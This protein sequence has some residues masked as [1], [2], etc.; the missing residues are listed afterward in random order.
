MISE[1]KNNNTN[2]N[3]NVNKEFVNLVVI[4]SILVM[5]V[6]GI[7]SF[8]A[9]RTTINMTDDAVS[10]V[11]SF[12]LEAM[13]DQRAQTISN[14][15]DYNF[16]HMEKAL[17]VL[18]SEDINTQEDLR[19][20]L[21]EIKT[22]LSL[23]RFALVDEDN[24]VYTQYTTYSGGSRYEFLSEE[25]L[26]KR[27]IST[28]SQYG[29]S[30]Q[31]CLAIPA[32]DLTIMGKKFKACFVQI[33][34]SEIADLLAFDE[35]EGSYFSLYV[36]NGGNLSDN[37]HGMLDKGENIL[38]ASREYLPQKSWEKL[39]DDFANGR[40]GN[41]TL[42]SE[43]RKE[44]I[45]YVPVH[46]TGW[47]LV[48]FIKESIINEQIHGISE[49]NRRTSRILIGV[50]LLS[51]VLFALVIILRLRKISKGRI[52]AEKENS[53][54]F[55]SMANTDSLTGIRNKH[56]Y[57]QYE[58]LMN[59]HIKDGT[60]KDNLAVLVCDINGL[61]HVN[62]TKGHAAGD[63]LIKDASVLI[64]EYFKHGAVFRIG[65]D[66]FVVV[67][68]EKGYDTLHETLDSIN[69]VIEENIAKESVVVSIGYSTLQEDD[70]E[71]HDVF[72]RADKMMYERK[73]QLKEMGSKTREN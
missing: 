55:F 4:G 1:D 30:K 68:N 33:D 18:E 58:S 35:N 38:E 46:D 5:L 37:D 65:G 64:C 25:N 70:K 44:E 14:L 41:L 7:S 31:L 2:T 26:D 54:M 15:I 60:V 57:S 21:G 24:I 51:M 20:R 59:Q 49:A 50:T 56:A 12:Y 40:G 36:Q 43:E 72:Q 61:K 29:S 66:E 45:C 47:M 32:D 6:L 52:E 53:R 48:V 19:K 42:V 13:A 8:S 3:T 11:S 62:D 27:V 16:E 22:I 9:S 17:Y 63:Q 67:L 39:C 28:I 73:K 69:K 10:A 34:I 71:I 23:N